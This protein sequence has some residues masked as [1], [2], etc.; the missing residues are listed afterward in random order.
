GEGRL[1]EVVDAM[2]VEVLVVVA[3]TVVAVSVAAMSLAAAI[4]VVVVV[5][6]AVITP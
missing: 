1:T 3:V 4:G 6:G 5:A 2:L